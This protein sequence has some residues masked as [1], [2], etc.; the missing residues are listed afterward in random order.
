[1]VLGA[2]RTDAGP[3]AADQRVRLA[4]SAVQTAVEE[5]VQGLGAPRGD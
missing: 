1:M 4:V 2:V 3:Q 5:D